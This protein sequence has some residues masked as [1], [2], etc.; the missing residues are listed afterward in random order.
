MH[1]KYFFGSVY[2]LLIWRSDLTSRD[3]WRD[4]KALPL[5]IY[6]YIYVHKYIPRTQMTHFVK[7]AAH[8]IEGPKDVDRWVLVYI[9]IN[10]KLRQAN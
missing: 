7:D 4:I 3:F 6:I 2:R 8:K 1:S 5:Y 10:M 9:Y